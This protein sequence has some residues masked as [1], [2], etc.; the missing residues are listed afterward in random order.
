MDEIKNFNDFV[1]ES[2]DD[3]DPTITK[4]S[5]GVALI[6]DGKIL[7]VHPTNGTWQR[8]IC[9]IPKGKMEDGEDP[10][11]AALRELK[12]ETGIVL[13]QNQLLPEPYVVD[14]YNKKGIVDRQ[15][16]YFE[17]HIDN[18]SE[19]GITDI[20]LPKSMLQLEEIDWAKFVNIIDAYPI[21]SRAQMI[22][23][24]RLS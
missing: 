5:A 13:R 6:Y 8:G 24:D 15:L 21:I 12:E 19:I 22:I 14:M 4:N 16:I 1:N 11:E 7:L 3:I 9:G 23:L 2:Y 20:K 10:I 18:L 17:C